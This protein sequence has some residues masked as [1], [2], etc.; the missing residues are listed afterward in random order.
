MSKKTEYV[1]CTDA[2]D[3]VRESF[4]RAILVPNFELTPEGVKAF[5][6]SRS[7][8]LISIYLSAETIDRFKQ[9]AVKTGGR[10]QTM[11]SDVLDAYTHQYL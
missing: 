5:A 7:K 1:D 10:Y 2:P 8:K 6:E 11:I 4:D 9:E 3:D